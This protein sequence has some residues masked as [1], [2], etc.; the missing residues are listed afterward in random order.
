MICV[1]IGI[2]TCRI[3]PSAEIRPTQLSASVVD[4]KPQMIRPAHRYG[5][6]SCIGLRNNV[7]KIT[8]IAAMSTAILMESQKAPTFDLRYRWAISCHPNTAAR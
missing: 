1:K 2:L 6:K 3:I 5:R 7:P 8:P 4:I